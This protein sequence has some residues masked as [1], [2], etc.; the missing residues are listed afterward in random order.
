MST[1]TLS[2]NVGSDKPSKNDNNNTKSTYIQR[3][4]AKEKEGDEKIDRS[5]KSRYIL[6]FVVLL[7]FRFYFVVDLYTS[8][9]SITEEVSLLPK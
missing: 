1:R 2:S 8:A 9:G 7:C 6:I 4:N 3:Y 5:Y